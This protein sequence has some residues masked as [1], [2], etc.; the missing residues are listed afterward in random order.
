MNTRLEIAFL[1][2]TLLTL[3]LFLFG[4]FEKEQPPKHKPARTSKCTRLGFQSVPIQEGL[5]VLEADGHEWL[6]LRGWQCMGMSHR[7][8]CRYCKEK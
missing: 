6:V 5:Y 8:S 7:P 2:L 4:A 1:C 3:V